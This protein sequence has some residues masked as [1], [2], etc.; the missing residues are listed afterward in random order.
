MNF[1]Y[2]KCAT[3]LNF[4]HSEFNLEELSLKFAEFEEGDIRFSGANFNCT[5]LMFTNT[6]FGKGN[7][8]FRQANFGES[9]VSF[10]YARFDNGD[11]TFDKSKFRGDFIDFRKV[12]F[13]NGKTD[14][15]RVDFGNGNINFSESEFKVGK[16]SFRSSLFGS[17][18]KK[19]ENVD[20]G[21]NDVYFDDTVFKEG[22]LCF[23]NSTFKLLSLADC[24][25]G[26]H[27]DFRVKKGNFLDLSY[28]VIKDVVDFHAGNSDM[29]LKTL[30]IEGIKN[31]GKLF[32]SWKKN[33]AFHLIQSQK[34]SSFESKAN[35]FH[36]LKESFHQNGK[37]NSEDSAYVAFK[38]YEMAS[39][40]KLG[41]E[42][43]GFQFFKSEI[44]YFFRW[45]VFDK[46]GLFATAPL[47][48]FISMIVV[49]TF[50]SLLY[51]ILPFFVDAAILPSVEHT[52][53]LSRL[54]TAFYHSAI[55][56]FTIGYGDYFPSG[57][58]TW[59]SAIEGW[60]GVFL[61]SYFT[62]A[63]VRKILR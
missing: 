27:C 26:G 16:I 47:R 57:H 60:A 59:L 40:R 37:F 38:R 19:F 24:N 22:L 8:N 14:F 13:G 9:H 7:V 56:F 61:M 54:G 44:S 11:V 53:E 12:E 52:G 62:V 31:M 63:F 50:F 17:G 2:T 45:L 6:N 41:K 55:T 30:K 36:I 15:K 25:L 42:A 39:D 58:I 1:N 21:D 46:A 43:G 33:D 51:A 20:F 18:E 34:L 4:N 3:N 48:V 10:Q 5:D 35:Q 49:L 28:S 23:K 32:I 29:Y